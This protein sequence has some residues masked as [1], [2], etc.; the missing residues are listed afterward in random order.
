VQRFVPNAGIAS[1]RLNSGK[2]DESEANRR[3]QIWSVLHTG[4]TG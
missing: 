4:A 3:G 2:F 1:N